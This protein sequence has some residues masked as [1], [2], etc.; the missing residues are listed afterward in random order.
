MRLSRIRTGLRPAI[1]ALAGV[2]MLLAI[3]CAAKTRT[4][5][6]DSATDFD[7]IRRVAVLPF[8]NMTNDSA[9]GEKA[10][11]IFIIELLSLEIVEVVDPGE[12]LRVLAEKRI[13][14]IDS[15]GDE[16]VKE[17][18]EAMGA[19]ALVFGAVH[20]Y[21]RDRSGQ[22]TA[23]EVALSF[24]MLD[25]VEARTVWTA[26]VSRA[27]ASAGSRMFGVSSAT[28]TE[29]ARKLVREAL[30]TLVE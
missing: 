1:A 4:A 29:A 27:G 9:A 12:V 16:Q 30:E 5:Y 26:S 20:A 10:R 21:T 15:L 6:I 2:L 24:R 13:Q 14:N 7:S 28:E 3:G 11:R 25:S 23:P 19:D 8:E 22:V 18:G 17:L